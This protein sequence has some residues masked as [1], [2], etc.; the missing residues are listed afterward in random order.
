MSPPRDFLV[1]IGKPCPTSA[2]SGT[3]F[4]VFSDGIHY[5]SPVKPARRSYDSS[6]SWTTIPCTLSAVAAW[7]ATVRR[8]DRARRS[9]APGSSTLRSPILIEAGMRPLLNLTGN[10]LN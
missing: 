2:T 10:R 8:R 5:R 7:F 3:S 6:T 4:S 9:H 1:R